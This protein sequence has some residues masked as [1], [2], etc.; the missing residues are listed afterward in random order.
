MIQIVK[1]E[2]RRNQWLPQRETRSELYQATLY[3]LQ[4]EEEGALVSIEMTDHFREVVQEEEE[5]EEVEDSITMIGEEDKIEG[6][7]SREVH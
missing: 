7:W 1:K 3:L 6:E 5:E 4:D 2:R